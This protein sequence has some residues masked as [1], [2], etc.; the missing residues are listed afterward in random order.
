[1][2]THSRPWFAQ[3]A[4]VN[5]S[6][7]KPATV[8][9]SKQKL[10]F[11][12]LARLVF[13]QVAVV[14]P[15]FKNPDGRLGQLRLFQNAHSALADL[16]KQSTPLVHSHF[17][18]HHGEEKAFI[19]TNHGTIRPVAIEIPSNEGLVIEDNALQRTKDVPAL[20]GQRSGNHRV[21]FQ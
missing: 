1:M 13:S 3:L 2:M 5:Y 11:D 7:Q 14:K 20:P 19:L 10:D 21:P 15:I 9:F 16:A 18:Q 12:H 17:A 6:K 4:A 8:N